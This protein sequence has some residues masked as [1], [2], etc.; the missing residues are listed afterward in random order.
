MGRGAG[1]HTP[2]ADTTHACTGVFTRACACSACTQAAHVPPHRWLQ[3]T[4]AP[5]ARRG[6]SPHLR[7]PPVPLVWQHLSLGTLGQAHTHVCTLA[8]CLVCTRVCKGLGGG[9][10]WRAALGSTE[11]LG[12]ALGGWAG[13]RPRLARGWGETFLAALVILS[14]SK[15]VPGMFLIPGSVPAPAA[16]ALAPPPPPRPTPGLP[17]RSPALQQHQ[18]LVWGGSAL[19][20]GLHTPQRCPGCTHGCPSPGVCPQSQAACSPCAGAGARTRDGTPLLANPSSCQGPAGGLL[21]TRHPAEPRQP[22]VLPAAVAGH[23]TGCP[24]ERWVA[25]G[26][27]GAG[28]PS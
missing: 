25:P 13:Q 14:G 18:G 10:G 6:L 12:G 21:P 20:G 11:G 7:G 16:P 4:P 9:V 3:G 19:W 28:A 8:A 22:H 27:C 15:S 24:G 5:P 23:S 2:H 17:A 1:V 26:V